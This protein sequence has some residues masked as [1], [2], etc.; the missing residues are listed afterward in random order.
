MWCVRV[1]SSKLFEWFQ[2]PRFANQ[3]NRATRNSNKSQRSRRRALNFVE[4]L[5]DRRKFR[6]GCTVALLDQGF[7]SADSVR[8]CAEIVGFASASCVWVGASF[9]RSRKGGIER[10]S[11]VRALSSATADTP[12]GAESAMAQ[13]PNSRS[14][15][16]RFAIQR[17]RTLR[18]HLISP[19]LKRW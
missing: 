3:R 16:A 2:A 15:A 1:T 19:L 9:V 5:P 10:S 6:F 18:A 13:A 11:V 4:R 7:D 17:P 12:P 8:T 14:S